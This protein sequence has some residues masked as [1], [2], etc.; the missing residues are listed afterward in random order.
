MTTRMA[1]ASA[2]GLGRKWRTSARRGRG[3]DGKGIS[4]FGG[5]P[6]CQSGQDKRGCCQ[7]HLMAVIPWS[8]SQAGCHRPPPMG[9]MGLMGFIRPMSPI[10]PMGAQPACEMLELT[11]SEIRCQ[12]PV[13]AFARR[14]GRLPAFWRTRLRVGSELRKRSASAAVQRCRGPL[15]PRS[16]A[17]VG[18]RPPVQSA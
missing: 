3:G 5:L 18:R 6:L 16:R 9:R 15:G 13:A 14:R 10:R 11:I 7:V 1:V 4:Y 12:F 2:T 8:A 17:A